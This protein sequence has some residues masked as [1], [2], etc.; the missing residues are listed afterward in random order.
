MIKTDTQIKPYEIGGLLGS[1]KNYRTLFITIGPEN[2]NKLD[3]VAKTPENM[4]RGP[5]LFLNEERIFFGWFGSQ[6]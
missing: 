4:N 6:L 1:A 5:R 3:I 2:C